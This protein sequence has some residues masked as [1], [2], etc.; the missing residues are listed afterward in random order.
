MASR[1]ILIVSR[2]PLRRAD[3]RCR[4]PAAVPRRG[5][6]RL[7]RIG[8]ANR[9]CITLVVHP[10]CR[11]AA[12][13]PAITVEI[14]KIHRHREAARPVRRFVLSVGVRVRDYGAL[15][16]R[17]RLLA[18]VDNYVG[19]AVIA[20]RTGEDSVSA[21]VSPAS[22]PNL[23]LNRVGKITIR[24]VSIVGKAVE[25]GVAEGGAA[26]NVGEA[27]LTLL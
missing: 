14:V 2:A 4:P 25:T 26:I 18:L 9:F 23:I 15:A 6:A 11:I 8:I 20:Q 22:C 24:I 17:L 21:D 12:L 16:E 7:D 19:E 1:I 5:D 10:V 3:R 27:A 13:P